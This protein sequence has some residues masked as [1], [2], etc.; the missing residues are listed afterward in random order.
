MHKKNI[1]ISIKITIADCAVRFVPIE[2]LA[3]AVERVD[4]LDIWIDRNEPFETF[5][6]GLAL[7]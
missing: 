2:Q 5:H 4:N 7:K 1:T 3:K 6:N